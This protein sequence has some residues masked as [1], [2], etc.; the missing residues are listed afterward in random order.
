VQRLVRPGLLPEPEQ[1]A[2]LWER[3]PAWQLRP[4]P[5]QWSAA[6]STSP[7]SWLRGLTWVQAQDQEQGPP[8][9]LTEPLQE[10]RLQAEARRAALETVRRPTAV[11][12]RVPR[13]EQGP[14]LQV[15]AQGQVHPQTMYRIR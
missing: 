2:R 14:V 4:A 3:M 6:A 12:V 1:Q 8:L 13:G 10:L 11:E 5:E 15:P 9:V 7:S